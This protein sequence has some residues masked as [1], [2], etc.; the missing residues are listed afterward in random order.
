[1]SRSDLLAWL[2]RLRFS[3]LGAATLLSVNPRNLVRTR[4]LLR[5][6]ATWSPWSVL[7]ALLFII[8]EVETVDRQ[9]SAFDDTLSQ[10]LA[11]S[12]YLPACSGGLTALVPSGRLDGDDLIG[13]S[14]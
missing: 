13:P 10:S 8:T 4:R 5:H 9:R 1:M 6:R 11:W 3:Q 2:N 14:I 7:R 12:A